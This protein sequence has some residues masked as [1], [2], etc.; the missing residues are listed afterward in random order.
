[1]SEVLRVLC[2]AAVAALALSACGGGGG[3]SPQPAAGAPAPAPAD[4]AP[5]PTPDPR[6][7]P[8]PQPDPTPTPEPRPTPPAPTPTPPA[9]T[10]L[11]EEPVAPAPP[12]PSAPSP[13][14]TPPPPATGDETT[15]VEVR[16]DPGEPPPDGP[17]PPSS[18]V[19]RPGATGYSGPRPEPAAVYAAPAEP[20]GP[21][22]RIDDAGFR[23]AM[24]NIS[25]AWGERSTDPESYADDARARWQPALRA[26]GAYD[27]YARGLSGR[28][29][30]IAVEDGGIDIL[31]AQFARRVYDEGSAHVYSRP[32]AWDENTGA[33]AGCAAPGAGCRVYEI[34]AEGEADRIE[35][36]ARHI[37]RRH[38]Y[39]TRDDS[40]FIL[41]TS[42]SGL[43]AWSE[44][45][46]L[47][48][49]GDDGGYVRAHGTQVASV[50]LGWR[51]GIAPGAEL[52]AGAFNFDEQ[53]EEQALSQTI[54]GI[55]DGEIAAPEGWDTA[56]FDADLARARRERYAHFHIVN[57]SYGVPA[58]SNRGLARQQRT[59]AETEAWLRDN[60]PLTWRAITQTDVEEENKT[61]E[62]FAAGND[63][64]AQP[65]VDATDAVRIPDL[66]G[67][68]FAVA[69]LGS[70]SRIAPFSNRCGPLPSDWD[71][72]RH[73]RHYCLAA[74]GVNI[75]AA[76]PDPDPTVDAPGDPDDF[77]LVN[78]TSFAAPLV[79]GGLALVS[80]AFR[81]QLSPREI[82]LRLVD[83]ANNRGVYAN[84]LIYGAG[85]LDVAEATR[86]I[87]PLSV[88]AGGADA[89]LASTRFVAPASWGDVG[90]R[91][92]D[93]EIASFDAR[94]APFWSGARGLFATA[95]P[96][97]S[98]PRFDDDGIG[99]AGPAPHLAWA[100][101]PAGSLGLANFAGGDPEARVALA[102][103]PGAGAPGDAPNWSAFGFSA[104]PFS[105]PLRVGFLAETRTNQGTAPSGAF[106]DA[107]RAQFVWAA[108]KH[109]ASWGALGIELDYMV[110]A[111]NAEYPPG[112]MFDAG[113]AVYT[114]GSAALMHK[115]ASG[116]TRL[117]LSQPPR[118]ETG[119]GVFT[120]PVGR[121]PGGERLYESRAVPLRPGARETELS[122]RHRR[123]AGP[124]EVVLELS[125]ARDAGHVRG[126][127]RA[128]AGAAWRL[129]R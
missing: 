33:F 15:D 37:I 41:D 128:Y 127:G 89:L 116:E 57:R 8:A 1:M 92:G 124:G 112:A 93:I 55:I 98:I 14:D 122:L 120:Y 5:A 69:A 85:L 91:I 59:R 86:P 125:L 2:A 106:G 84:A 101:V 29:V 99:E 62:V 6:P 50:A 31:S 82:G 123:A 40:W 88:G 36:F 95:A 68:N 20:D 56:A 51:T 102:A 23:A 47:W 35:R 22:A 38:G 111:G 4:P 34:D 109:R 61:L 53:A 121:T 104:R 73:G 74:P 7:D 48:E 115:G 32:F 25:S 110:A 83:T 77:D 28:G 71:V 100:A 90:A 21:A 18:V 81:G 63:M 94:N 45:P 19:D 10:P 44:I 108:R 54:V 107:A 64:L 119:R 126:R 66:R 67:L 49:T 105:F 11:P 117:A 60:L 52:V 118:A 42:Q 24:A 65:W 76:N 87:G 78:G 17:A 96:R 70:N 39:P 129:R 103:A 30:R 9:P 58:F 97:V 72:S 43:L 79:A 46:A 3:G 114:A 80:E 27:A 12:P 13:E 26:V 113:S 75:V 16:V